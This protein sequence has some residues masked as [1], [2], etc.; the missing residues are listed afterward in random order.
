LREVRPNVRIIARTHGDDQAIAEYLGEAYGS[1]QFTQSR[2]FD[3]AP[4]LVE[5]AGRVC[6]RSFEPGLNPNVQKVRRDQASYLENILKSGHGSVLEHVSWTFMLQDVSRVFTHELVRHRAGTAISQESMRYVRLDDLPFWFPEWAQADETV[7][8]LVSDY[9]EQG[10][11]LQAML[12]EHFGLDEEGVPFA[13]KKAKTSFMRRFAPGGHATSMVWTANA[14]ALRHI[15]ESRTAA[16]AE[17][18]I[19]LVFSDIATLMKETCPLLFGD[20]R[21]NIDGAWVPKWSKV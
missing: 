13:E 8:T 3:E 10:E 6:Y 4:D 1:M 18:E 12:A 14:R 11:Q 15:I 21:V 19:R 5:F 17:E 9:L 16:G 2:M 20:F 7:M